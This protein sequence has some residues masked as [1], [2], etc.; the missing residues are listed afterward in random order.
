[1]VLPA[2]VGALDSKRQRDLPTSGLPGKFF[3]SEAAHYNFCAMAGR[4]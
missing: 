2:Y 1:M 4:R 3:R